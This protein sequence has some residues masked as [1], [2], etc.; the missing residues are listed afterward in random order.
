M[1][2]FTMF[3]QEDSVL[4][5]RKHKLTFMKKTE[6][7]SD[8]EKYCVRIFITK[9]F[10][11]RNLVMFLTADFTLNGSSPLCDVQ[12]IYIYITVIHNQNFDCV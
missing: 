11:N 3:S 2:K 10:L 6:R 7:A 9:I 8:L 1:A 4:F 5:S 12:S